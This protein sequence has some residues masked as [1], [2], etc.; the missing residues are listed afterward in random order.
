MSRVPV[1]IERM[2]SLEGLAAVLVR[3]EH[4][5]RAGFGHGD[6][7]LNAPVGGGHQ[8]PDRLSGVDQASEPDCYPVGHRVELLERHGRLLADG[9]QERFAPEAPRRPT[10]RGGERA[11]LRLGDD[12]H[13]L[14][15]H[16]RNLPWGR[17]AGTG[18]R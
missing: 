13:P 12:R 17:Y 16:G 5:H 1:S 9:E 4:R 8:E 2:T 14:D 11:L 18:T 3:H 6:H 15:V 7:R 10:D